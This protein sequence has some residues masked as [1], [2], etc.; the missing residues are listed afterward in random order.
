M[1][2]PLQC[3]GQLKSVKSRQVRRFDDHTCIDVHGAGHDHGDS[4]KRRIAFLT[5][6]GCFNDSSYD[7]F[8]AA[9]VRGFAFGA[10]M[11]FAVGTD[12]RDAQV[13]TAQIGSNNSRSGVCL[14]I[15]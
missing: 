7:L 2:F 5:C 9:L 1:K 13:R 15:D 14:L 12:G 11:D 4:A 8:S 6:A 10:L 3:G